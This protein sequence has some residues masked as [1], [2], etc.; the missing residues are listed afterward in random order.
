MCGIIGICTTSPVMQDIYDGLVV[1]QHRGQDSAG[2]VTY[3]GHFYL[4]KGNGYVRDV[5]QAK[6]IQRLKGLVGIGHVRYPTAGSYDASEAQPFY[7]NAPFGLAMIHNGNLT[8]YSELKDQVTHLNARYLN[9]ASD[10]EV[11]LNV[12][13]DEIGRIRTKHLSPEQIFRA[14][15]K[16]YKRLKG[17]YSVLCIIAGHGLL[18]FRDPHGIRPLVFG[19]RDAAAG[20]EYV[21]ASESVALNTLGFKF[22]RDV[23]PGEAIFIDLNRQ[24]FSKQI[25]RTKWAPCIFEYVYLARPDSV[26]DGVSVYKSRLRMGKFLAHKIKKAMAE[27]LKIDVVMP[28]PDTAR[29]ASFEI[30]SE[31]GLPCREGLIKNRYIGRTFIM[32]GQGMRKRSIKYKL[33]PIPLEIEGKNILLIDDSIVRGNTS[34]KIIE[35]VREAGAKKVYFASCCPPLRN[36]CVYGVDM[37]SRKDFIANNLSIEEIG[38]AIGADAIFYQE[39]K[40]LVSAVQAGN[41]KIKNFCTACLGGKYPTSDIT[42]EVLQRAELAR[43]SIQ[44]EGGGADNPD[45]DQLVLI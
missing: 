20:R 1:L 23:K 12:L 15:K 16:V 42:E 5:F 36:P 29:S 25:E 14:L 18:A 31:L 13:A 30:A 4:K 39:L 2:M 22:V 10:S 27:G 19:Q 38:K 44:A 17:S 43:G 37:P 35:M 33:N 40:D 8:N 45:E 24:V 9:T 28:I 11:L 34:R 6:H 3:D 7:V 26:L 32:P 21:I 41:P